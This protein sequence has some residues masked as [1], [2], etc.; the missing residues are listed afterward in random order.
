MEA[1][2]HAKRGFFRSLFI[3]FWTI[4]SSIA[5]DL[6]FFN[7]HLDFSDKFTPCSPGIRISFHLDSTTSVRQLKPPAI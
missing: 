1:S 2:E 4:S 5:L 7:K 3:S 6:G